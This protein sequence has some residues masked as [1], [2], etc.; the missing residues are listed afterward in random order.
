MSEQDKLPVTII[1]DEED[2]RASV[3]QWLDLSGFA[4]RTFDSATAALDQIDPDYPGVVIS[5]VRMPGL[6]GLELL[7]LLQKKDRT[8]PVIMITGHGDV[9]MA[10]EAMRAGAYDFVEKPFDPERLSDLVNRA[11]A[12]R[13]LTIDN[14]LLRRELADG[15]VLLRQIMGD[16]APVT[17]LRDTILDYAHA[18]APILITGERGA[19]RS[20]VARA[21]H[22]AGPHAGHPFLTLNCAAEAPGH[23]EERVF[24]PDRS[25]NPPL[26]IAAGQ[27]MV[28]LENIS[29]LPARLQARLGQTLTDG[30]MSDGTPIR[31]RIATIADEKVADEVAGG[32]FSPGLYYVLS[33]LEITTPPLRSVGQDVLMLF[34]HYV[35]RFAQDYDTA[36]PD[37][38]AED[39][40][41]LLEHDWPGNHRQLINI[42]E[43]F[44]LRSRQGASAVREVLGE[45][46]PEPTEA[47]SEAKLRPLKDHVEAFERL[48]IEAA[49]RRHHGA[50]APVMDEL[51]L[52]RR[53]LNEKMA[54]YGISRTDFV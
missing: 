44:V 19:G 52:P 11:G 32:Q 25:G 2:M 8:L 6:D 28:V 9:T 46:I 10:V 36:R 41:A 40:A 48:Q 47:A 26:L 15:T 49:L 21:L 12:A 16:S 7:A 24:S 33:A 4:P 5:D 45:D 1:D 14:R 39:A 43:R 34:E 38:G 20:L 3:S 27:G 30:K 18:D 17:R 51:A 31:A 42:A 22:A 37:I 23:I 50:I 29:A 54:K 13:R 53:T 35:D